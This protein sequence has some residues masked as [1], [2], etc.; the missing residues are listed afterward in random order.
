MKALRITLLL[1]FAIL[2]GYMIGQVITTS[3]DAIDNDSIYC[4]GGGQLTIFEDGSG[5]CYTHEGE[6]TNMRE[7]YQDMTF[8]YR[9]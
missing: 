1:A 7:T 6:H 2:I 3:T 5:A 8:E 9:R 4:S